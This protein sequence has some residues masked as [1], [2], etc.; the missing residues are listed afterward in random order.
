MKKICLLILTS[1]LLSAC[2][3]AQATPTS[4]PQNTPTA[5]VKPSQTSTPGP[6]RTPLGTAV[7]PFQTLNPPTATGIPTKT[8]QPRPTAT[9]RPTLTPTIVPTPTPITYIRD[10]HHIPQPVEAITGENAGQMVE[11][12][13]LGYGAIE[14]IQHTTDQ[15]Y[16]LIQTPL[17]V[18]AYY[19]ST[20]DQAWMFEVDNRVTA[21]TASA[22]GWVALGSANGEVY[23]LSS[24]DGHLL[25]HDELYPAPISTM[26]FSEEGGILAVGGQERD[27]TL[28]QVTAER[29]FK[30][31]YEIRYT[32]E[33]YSLGFSN[34]D[35]LLLINHSWI[36]N[37]ADGSEVRRLPADSFTAP[38]LDLYYT[39]GQVRRISDDEIVLDSLEAMGYSNMDYY[40]AV[41]SPNGEYFALAIEGSQYSIWRIEDGSLVM[42]VNLGGGY[43]ADYKPILRSGPTPIHE[44]DFSPDGRYLVLE[45]STPISFIIE[46]E[47]IIINLETKTIEANFAFHWGWTTF[48]PDSKSFYFA[49][50]DSIE[51][52]E[53]PSGKQTAYIFWGWSDSD[54][55]FSPGTTR[56]T[57]GG[58][59]WNLE[60]GALYFTPEKER[61]IGFNEN[62][63]YIYTIRKMW[64]L[65]TRRTATFA[66]HRQIQLEYPDDDPDWFNN[67]D[68]LYW[69]ELRK[70]SI[71][72]DGSIA[73]GSSW[74]QGLS[75][76]YDPS[77]GELIKIIGSFSDLPHFSPNADLLGYDYNEERIHVYSYLEY[78]Q[79][80]PTYEFET[81]QV[82]DV[83]FTQNDQIYTLSEN[84][85]KL[86]SFPDGE[87]IT[88]YPIGWEYSVYDSI[89]SISSDN[90]IAVIGSYDKVGIWDLENE[91]LISEFTTRYGYITSLSFSSDGRY[92]AIGT[93]RGIVHLFG[94]MP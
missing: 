86:F 25:Q 57:Y 7:D 84:A 69:T 94:I 81:G 49:Q 73:A 43:G 41:F 16:T 36:I 90:R 15:G 37:T 64:W 3:R 12:A 58:Q 52:R 45:G 1:V 79:T 77:N 34:E 14:D 10:H 75:L 5:T 92:L 23:L 67:S 9:P 56:L 93:D 82:I 85:I 28:W 50:G 44:A 24:S 88:T 53:I 47:L 31:L 27:V 80:S 18:H 70:W 4:T 13:R 61:I 26:K 6:T 17:G 19:A 29:G 68:I 65:V 54:V 42:T 21:M 78:E 60:N 83:D 46:S 72:A 87:L 38:E 32:D 33:V 91:T 35:S 39:D 71:P 40:N 48:A 89:F 63:N 20:L 66:L 59:M 55:L 22:N 74:N 30:L 51:L 76:T 11:I 62:G 8:R 2:G